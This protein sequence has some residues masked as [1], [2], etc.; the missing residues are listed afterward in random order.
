VRRARRE[1]S[2]LA[3]R[4]PLYWKLAKGKLTVW[5]AI[6]AL[7]GYLLAVPGAI[8]PCV[9]AALGVGTLLTSASAQSMNQIYEIPRDALMARTAAR[10]LPSGRISTTEAAGFALATSS[11]GLGIL[12]FGANPATAA[13]AG[14]TI[15][16]YVCAYTPMKVLTPYNTHVGAISGSLPTL[17]GFYAAL[18]TSLVTSPWGGHA[19]WLF[20]MQTLWQMPHFYALAW[21][22]RADYLKG[23]YNMFPLTDVT[24]LKTAAMSRPYLVA[25]CAMPWAA[26]ALGLASWMLP[27]GAAIPSALWWQSLRRFEQNPSIPTCRRFFLG[28]LTYLLATLALFTVYARAEQP[29]DPLAKSTDA[30][31]GQETASRTLEPAWRLR[32]SKMFSELCPHETIQTYVLGA[33][34]FSC[35]FGGTKGSA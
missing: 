6:S 34:K 13:I 12:T 3:S 24:G 16:T 27:I 28:S 35:P 26:S 18:G 11:L 25:M 7:P 5:V 30:D 23:G 9:F 1:R 2:L 20:T 29:I 32:I 17:L 10:P 33:L 21:I 22:F 14:M 31:E 15:V 19:L 4:P 8:D